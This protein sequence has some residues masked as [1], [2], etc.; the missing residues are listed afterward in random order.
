MS[1]ISPA[2]CFRSNSPRPDLLS[3]LQAGDALIF[4]AVP[5]GSGQRIGVDWD[6]DCQL[7]GLDA[8]PTGTPDLN[9]DHVVNIADL[10][11]MLAN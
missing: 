9:G 2:S 8:N 10:G 7:N 4:M 11:R 3:S 1:V 5:P 6:L